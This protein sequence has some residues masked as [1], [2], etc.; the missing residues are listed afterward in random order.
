[1]IPIAKIVN[2]HAAAQRYTGG[3]TGRK[4]AVTVGIDDQVS[5]CRFGSVYRYR[6]NGAGF[7]YFPLAFENIEV[8][9]GGGVGQRSVIVT[10]NQKTLIIRK[11]GKV[12]GI[13]GRESSRLVPE[14]Y[15]NPVIRISSLRLTL[16]QGLTVIPSYAGDIMV[17]TIAIRPDNRSVTA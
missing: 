13:G 10:P 11:A 3:R 5:G 15:R 4:I 16:V 9:N 7:L 8:G 17:I 1:M 6:A 14:V 2:G 12:I